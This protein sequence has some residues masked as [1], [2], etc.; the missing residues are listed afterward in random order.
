VI[1]VF[2]YELW[3]HESANIVGEFESEAKAFAF[4]RSMIEA[5]G[6]AVTRPWTLAIEDAEG[7]TTMIA[8]GTVLRDRASRATTTGSRPVVS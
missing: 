2:P 8:A 7:D 3:N 4:V 1:D 5:H 6:P